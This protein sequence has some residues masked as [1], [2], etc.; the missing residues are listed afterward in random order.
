M[1]K[2][3]ILITLLFTAIVLFFAAC[4]TTDLTDPVITLS[5]SGSY[6]IELGATMPDLTATAE[7]NKDG[8]ITTKIVITGKPDNTDRAGEYTITY[9]VTDLAGNTATANRTLKIK[10]TNLAGNYSVVET[11]KKVDFNATVTQSSVSANFNILNV[12]N[13][14]AYGPNN[15]IAIKVTP[16]GLVIDAQ[17]ITVGPD[18]LVIA[19]T[20]TY[21]KT[22]AD[23]NILTINFTETIGTQ[24][25]TPYSDV[26]TR[27]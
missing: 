18:V 8:N 10:S 5:G 7:D 26:Y 17:S 20:G 27:M 24:T 13:F 6:T 14:G 11:G 4:E 2:T 3:N 23:Y 9:T 1:K 22:G 25:P 16:T 21:G 19:G 15:S 12:A